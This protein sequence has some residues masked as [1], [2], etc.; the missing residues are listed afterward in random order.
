MSRP[1]LSIRCPEC[2][3]VHCLS[4]AMEDADG[5][6]FIN[7]M[8][9]LP[10]SV[11]SPLI[12]YLKLFKPGKQSG[13]RWSRMYKLSVELAP[14][15]KGAQVERNRMSYTAPAALWTQCMVELVDNPPET[16]K[17]P[18]TGNGYLIS[19]VAN[20]AD[21]GA[22]KAEKDREQKAKARSQYSQPMAAKAFIP[23]ESKPIKKENVQHHLQQLKKT[24]KGGYNHE[25]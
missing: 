7:L 25:Q 24:T 5:Q 21:Q 20:Q 1:L 3:A 13:L 10:P 9:E 4:Q 19:M 11:I 8:A 2:G 6:R 23:E 15:I 12:R 14:M 16:L 18:L 17:L 22:A